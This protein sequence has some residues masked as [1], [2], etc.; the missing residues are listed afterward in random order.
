MK[1]RIFGVILC[2]FLVF[3]LTGCGNNKTK[4]ITCTIEDN[5]ESYKAK[6]TYNI[7][8]EK[9]MTL[10]KVSTTAYMEILSDD[11]EEEDFNDMISTYK[12]FESQIN[13][14]TKDEYKGVSAKLEYD[15]KKHNFSMTVTY[16]VKNMSSKL[17][18]DTEFYEYIDSDLK[19][20]IEKFREDMNSEDSE[21]VCK[22]N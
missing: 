6:E 13:D 10:S 16:D 2:G 11:I 19:F 4:T 5:D 18:A 7:V 15:E 22:E 12:D 14:G 21:A 8:Y 17:L 9:D 1:K 20:D 3:S